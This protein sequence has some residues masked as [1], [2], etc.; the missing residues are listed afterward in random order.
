MKPS[1]AAE[2]VPDLR[3]RWVTLEPVSD[4]NLPEVDA[5]DARRA[6]VPEM[7]GVRARSAGGRFGPLML[8]RE[9]QSGAAVGTLESDEMTGYPGVAVLIVFADSERSRPGY[10]MEACGLYIPMLFQRGAEILHFEVLSFNRQMTHLLGRSHRPPDVR[11]RR[12]AYVGGHFWDLLMYGFD[13][14]EWE[15]WFGRFR[16]VLERG[17]FAA[18]GGGRP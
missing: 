14:Q 8:I 16:L 9:N 18:L 3:G 10:A 2:P 7:G 1:S 13:R 15:A 17:S 12:H 6:L 5:L 4:A 11:M